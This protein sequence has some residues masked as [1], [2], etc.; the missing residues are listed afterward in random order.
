MTSGRRPTVPPAGRVTL[1]EAARLSKLS[2]AEVHRRV[3][4]GLA[5]GEQDAS[6]IWTMAA[7]D[8]KRL[9]RR[10]KSDDPRKAVMVRVPVAEHRA[11]ERAA[12]RVPVATWL[13]R[14][15]NAA[16]GYQADEEE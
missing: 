12:G 14:L 7:A 4:N 5:P 3:S 16:S 8:A 9:K 11:W 6:G 13:R 15:G 2:Y 1:Q 10:Q